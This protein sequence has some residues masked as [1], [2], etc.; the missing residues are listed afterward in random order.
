MN[1]GL[2]NKEWSQFTRLLVKANGEQKVMIIKCTKQAI[3]DEFTRGWYAAEE[4]A[5]DR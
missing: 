2:T 3:S 5:R 4:I 1:E